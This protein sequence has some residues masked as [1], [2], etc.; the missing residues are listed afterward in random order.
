MASTLTAAPIVATARGPAA[1]PYPDV[2]VRCTLATLGV[3][4]VGTGIVL[5]GR[6]S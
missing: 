2:S 3:A 6:T 5:G 1:P 4:A